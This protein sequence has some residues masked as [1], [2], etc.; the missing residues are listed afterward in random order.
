MRIEVLPE[1]IKA[2]EKDKTLSCPIALAVRRCTGVNYVSAD[3]WA[4]ILGDHYDPALPWAENAP[5]LKIIETEGTQLAWIMRRF[6]WTGEMSPFGFE[7]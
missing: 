3:Y 4:I 2:G 5:N 1:D 7:L 6:D